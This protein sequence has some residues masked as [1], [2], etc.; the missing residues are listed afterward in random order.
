MP[1]QVVVGVD[2]TADGLRAARWAAA[3]ARLYGAGLRLVHAAPDHRRAERVL[4]AAQNAVDGAVSGRPV[5]VAS[6]VPAAELLVHESA[7]ASLVVLGSRGHGGFTG[8]LTGPTAITVAT[9][10]R[11][12][13]V[14]MGG[15]DE[16][17][18]GPVVVGVDGTWTSDAA[19]DFALREAS[20]LGTGLIAVHGLTAPVAGVGVLGRDRAEEVVAKR[21]SRRAAC[22]PDVEVR[23]EVLAGT[24]GRVLLDLAAT[25]QLVVV[26]SSRRTGYRG[27]LLRSTSQHL[28]HRAPCPVAVVRRD[29]PI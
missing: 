1:R 18:N 13:M 4:R 2:G 24:P 28:L 15:V 10:A 16:P 3:H 14:V 6:S 20:L 9:R 22:Y 8:L 26:G 11:C 5:T 21:L 29:H 27:P 25:A 7:D 12:P 23:Q 19:L 17:G